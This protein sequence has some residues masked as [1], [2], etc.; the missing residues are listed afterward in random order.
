[1]CPYT[2][3]VTPGAS[4]ARPF[5]LCSLLL[6]YRPTGSSALALRPK[7]IASQIKGHTRIGA[8]TAPE[9][10]P[11]A[12]MY[13][14]ASTKRPALGGLRVYGAR[15]YRPRPPAMCVRSVTTPVCFHHCP[16]TKSQEN[17]IPQQKQKWLI[18]SHRWVFSVE[19]I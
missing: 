11:R 16:T 13:P 9:Q 5:L 8:I 1:V 3:P 14:M 10:Q 2:P 4:R 12:S 6:Q 7:L 19:V 17:T 15:S 18:F